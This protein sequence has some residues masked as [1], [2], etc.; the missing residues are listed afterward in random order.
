MTS[1]PQAL[2]GSITPMVSA[3]AGSKRVLEDLQVFGPDGVGKSLSLEQSRDYCRTLTYAHYENFSVA[4]LLV[5]RSLRQHMANIYA[6][7]RW[8]DDLADET[9]DPS[10]AVPLLQ[11]WRDQLDACFEDRCSHPVFVA[12]HETIRTYRIEKPLFE[13]LLE[14]FEMD[15]WKNRYE[16][17][18]ELLKYCSG[19]ANPVGRM[20][21]KLANTQ[22]AEALRC[23]DSICT[24][25]QIANFCQDLSLDARRNR[26]YFP[27][28]HWG[29]FGIDEKQI[30]DGRPS[31]PLVNGLAAW[32]SQAQEFLSGGL[33]MVRL[34]PR[35]LARDIQLFARGGLALLE[36]IR[37]AE[38]DVWTRS[39]E[40]SKS[41]KMALLVRAFLFPRSIVLPRKTR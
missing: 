2:S 41:T 36:A 34:V 14:A 31:G 27:R 6:Y 30:L 33:P 16:S 7:C 25:L 39:I 29:R 22:S 9:G 4:S 20:L 28:E 35:W 1:P 18:A 32:C 5:P 21:L 26:I 11:W 23:S 8:S 19:S 12:L 24:G 38:Y 37:R 13:G 17:D 3:R 10:R 40:V 15:Q